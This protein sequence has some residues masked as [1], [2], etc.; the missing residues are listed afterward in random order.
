MDD[1]GEI[2]TPYNETMGIKYLEIIPVFVN[3]IKEL[4]QQNEALTNSLISVLNRLD[5]LEK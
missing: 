3:A 4:S 1:A 2:V 5:V